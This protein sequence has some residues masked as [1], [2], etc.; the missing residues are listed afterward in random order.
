M[1]KIPVLL[2]LGLCLLAAFCDRLKQDGKRLKVLGMSDAIQ[3]YLS[4]MDLFKQ[5]HQEQ[6]LIFNVLIKLH[7]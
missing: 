3:S 7:P 4:R 6:M 2:I 1:Q 5:C